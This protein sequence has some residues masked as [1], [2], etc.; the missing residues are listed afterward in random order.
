MKQ[1]A[2]T[3]L[4]LL[5]NHHPL[6]TARCLLASR[7]LGVSSHA[8]QTEQVAS[9]S[10]PVP[11]RANAPDRM[12]ELRERGSSAQGRA[13]F[14]SDHSDLARTASWYRG[15]DGA[16]ASRRRRTAEH[17]QGTHSHKRDGAHHH[18]VPTTGRQGQWNCGDSR[19]RRGI[20][21]TA[22]GSGRS[23]A[24]RVANPTGHHCFRAEISR[25]PSSVGQSSRS[26]L[27]R[28]RDQDGG[29]PAPSP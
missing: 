21:S 2:T 11:S 25:A 12:R 10:P 8:C 23:R 20:P 1:S 15:L 5:Q 3:N 7:H 6:W 24:C 26:I 18:G 22:L 17:R 16:G 4:T 13:L 29:S 19:S 27:P 9:R 14:A 28:L